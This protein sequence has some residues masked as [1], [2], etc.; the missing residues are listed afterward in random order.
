M[1]TT[2][3]NTSPLTPL[4]GVSCEGVEDEQKQG[5]DEEGDNLALGLQVEL[6]VDLRVGVEVVEELTL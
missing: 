6:D 5:T 3:T 4:L 1:L 2:F